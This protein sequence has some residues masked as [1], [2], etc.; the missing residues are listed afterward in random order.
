ME[1]RCR[2]ASPNGEIIEGDYVADSEA[3][4]IRAVPLS[5]PKGKERVRTIVGVGLFDFGDRDGTGSEVLLQH[6]L[7]VA[8][9]G[10][11][12]YIADTYNHRVKKLDPE[13]G[14]ATRFAGSGRPG[15][16]DGHQAEFNEPGGLSILAGDLYVA[17][18]NNHAVRIVEI[19]SARVRTLF[20]KGL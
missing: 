15:R 14:S 13:T 3:S 4:A 2:L 8:L 19:Q 10:G 11:Q 9:N 17:D 6:P 16:E 18:T 5:D 1:F 20:L 12:L 7:D